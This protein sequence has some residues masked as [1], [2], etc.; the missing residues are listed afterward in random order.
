MKVLLIEDDRA[1]G[2]IL[3]EAL[4]IH[5]WVV[6][7]ALDGETGLELANAQDYDLIMLDIGLPKLD[8]ITVCKQLRSRG[9]QTPILLLTGH[10]STE[11][12]VAGLD[13]GA[14]DYVTKPFDLDIVLARVRA[15]ARKG[16]SATPIITWD[17]IQLNS[18][19]GEVTCNGTRVHLTAKEY[20]LLELF[21]ANPKR[22]YSR[23]AILDHLW[24]FA[25]SPGEETVSTH[26]KCVR[27]KLKAAG[28][29]DPIETVHGLGYRLRSAPSSSSHSSIVEEAA[30]ELTQAT[31]SSR[32]QPTS[33]RGATP[34]QKAQ[35]VTSK[36]WNQFKTQYLEQVN[37]L[38]TLVKR[39]K[40]GVGSSEQQDCQRLA[41]KLIGSMGMFGL[42]EAS[43][44]ARLLEQ[45]M[46]TSSLE[47]VHITEATQRVQALKQAIA[48]AQQ[49]L[50][51]KAQP[52]PAQRF[53]PSSTRILI[54]DD[55][56]LL[57]DRLRIE[58]IAWNLQ[59]EI[60]TDLTVARQMIRQPS[61][62]LILLD[63][64][65]PGEE[66]GLTLMR[67][68]DQR[69]PKI[70]VVIVTAKED[71]RDRVTA[72]QLGVSAFLHKP[73][74]A[75]EILKTVT[76]ILNRT[77][78]SSHGDRLL[79]VDDDPGFL[80]GL[81]DLLSAHGVQVTT[82]SDLRTFWQVLAACKPDVL[83]LDLEM[84]EFNGL[85][86]CQVV[87][88]DPQWQHLK[89]LFLSAH[90]ETSVMAKAYAAGADDYLSKAI[91]MSDL[92]PRILNRIGR[93]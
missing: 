22:I 34:Q 12:Q 36:V 7:R 72:A 87:R 60:A 67:E 52:L 13:A 93:P 6:E 91:P 43:Q 32:P 35:A 42:I 80:Q 73:L 39:L 4:T 79:I 86:L 69:S 89:V 61:P 77:A 23:R 25:N 54:V 33:T 74:P 56:L 48:H 27:Q 41:H 82:T 19:S 59:V 81:A 16:K 66:N 45:L 50:P 3:T 2:D 90:T 85:E 11:A 5:H 65:F 1:I 14:D 46:Q 37:A 75:H 68:L 38:E 18:A 26:I 62:S 21:L 53:S 40:P 64:S 24:D 58:A 8:G 47:A 55:D 9:S 51:P 57:A 88:T 78:H 10:N 83:I 29:S 15:V 20:G 84:P 71:L 30:S 49:V 28:A 31:R 44:N 17:T 63:L 92:V 70:P 76:D